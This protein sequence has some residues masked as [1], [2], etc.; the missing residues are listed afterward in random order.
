MVQAFLKVSS[1]VRVVGQSGKW[2]VYERLGI[3]R[4]RYVIVAHVAGNGAEISFVEFAEPQEGTPG[5]SRPEWNNSESPIGTQHHLS[6][7]TDSLE[8]LYKLREQIKGAGTKC[9]KGM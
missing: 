6:F 4:K 2:V 5:V 7:K 3:R 1:R 8:H 9:S